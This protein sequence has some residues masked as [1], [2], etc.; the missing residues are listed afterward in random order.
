MKCIKSK[1]FRKVLLLTAIFLIS[2]D[3]NP[4][5]PWIEKCIIYKD[6]SYQIPLDTILLFEKDSNFVKRNGY[7]KIYNSDIIN[8]YSIGKIKNRK[9]VGLWKLYYKDALSAEEHYN[10][11]GEFDGFV[12]QYDPSNGNF[13]SV[14]HFN[15]GEQVGIQKEYYLNN[16]LAQVY[17]LDKNDQ[18]RDKFVCY[19]T[20]GKIIYKED[21]GKE[22]TGYYK[23]YNN[24]TIIREGKYLKGKRVGIHVQKEYF[25]SHYPLIENTFYNQKGG[26]YKVKLFGNLKAVI[27]TKGDSIVYDYT[28]NKT[29]KITFLKGKIIE[30]AVY[31][32]TVIF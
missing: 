32:D 20:K 3:K 28:K 27:Q 2:C 23:K 11:K 30:N 1:Y 9:K 14:Y 5:Q 13:L 15:N 19:N 10:D 29:R 16:I 18:Y 6:S 21:F 7:Y 22:G 25:Q 4:K 31:N 12:I 24:D 8:N 17:T 26:F